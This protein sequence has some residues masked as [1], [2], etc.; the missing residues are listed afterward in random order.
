[1]ESLLCKN[2]AISLSSSLSLSQRDW[3][4]LRKS[5]QG[6]RSMAQCRAEDRLHCPQRKGINC[7][8]LPEPLKLHII[9]Q[10]IPCFHQLVYL[11]HQLLFLL[12]LLVGLLILCSTGNTF[13]TPT[14][15][16]PPMARQ[17]LLCSRLTPEQIRVQ[18]YKPTQGKHL[19][20]DVSC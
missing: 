11:L 17:S 18:G 3:L 16:I 9:H 13:N 14:G 5:Q 19:D 8:Q 12:P 2:S 15:A 1:M 20:A 7:I 6:T 10:E 4:P